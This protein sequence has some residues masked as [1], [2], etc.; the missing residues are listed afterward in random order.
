[1]VRIA[2]FLYLVRLS[3]ML[4]C[5]T[6]VTYGT[7]GYV[8]YV[9]TL[10]FIIYTYQGR[11]GIVLA[12]LI[13]R[14]CTQTSTIWPFSITSMRA[15]G[16]QCMAINTF[17]AVLHYMCSCELNRGG[18][19]IYAHSRTRRVGRA[20]APCRGERLG[21]SPNFWSVGFPIEQTWHP[22]RFSLL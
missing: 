21:G 1:M 17:C 4:D 10:R 19:R 2:S 5:M 7:I 15:Y 14:T 11:R 8:G 22:Y 3:D 12:R 20:D 13:Q 9:Q 6:I 18:G 16:W